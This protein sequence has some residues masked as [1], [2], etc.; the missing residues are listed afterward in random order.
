LT[1]TIKNLSN[2]GVTNCTGRLRTASS[3]ITLLDTVAAF[4]S[5]PVGGS[6]H[7]GSSRFRF[8]ASA[9]TPKGTFVPFV[10]NLT[11]DAGYSQN[12]E[13]GVMVGMSGIQIIWGPKQVTVP[14]GDSHF[15]YG[16]GYNPNDNRL[17]VANAYARRI[18]YYTSDTMPTLQGNIPA[19]DTMTTDLKY[20]AYDNTFWIAANPAVRRVYKI[21]TAGTVLRQFA[22]PANDYPTGLAWLPSS[23]L[24]YLADRRTATTSPPEYVY[25]SDTLGTGT[26]MTIPWTGNAGVRGLAI[27]PYGPDTTL[28]MIYT[29]FNAGATNLDSV[30]IVEVRRSD[31]AVQNQAALP[32]WNARGIEYDPRDGNYWISLCQNPDRSIGKVAGFRGIPIGIAEN[33]YSALQQALVLAPAHPNPFRKDLVIAYSLPRPTKIKLSLYDV[34]GRLVITLVEGTEKAGLKTVQ[35]TGRASDGS[36]V[37]SG[38]YFCQLETEYGIRVQKVVHTR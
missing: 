18:P 20:C 7:N 8:L 26:Q 1:D 23:R 12:L 34:S 5:V 30:G 19:P 31:L 10:L 24:L 17:Y 15:L 3:Y 33:G 13:F 11:G 36:T 25:R 2:V 4:G 14:V 32:G 21:N 27:E 6:A 29:Y 35:W 16:M 28:L 38:V 9:S 37:A 22:N